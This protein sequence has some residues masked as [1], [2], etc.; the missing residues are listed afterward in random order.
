MDGLEC[1]NTSPGANIS[2]ELTI[3]L[4]HPPFQTYAPH[5]KTGK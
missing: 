2:L 3:M 4:R 5:L 1:F